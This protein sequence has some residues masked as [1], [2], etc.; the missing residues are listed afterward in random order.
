M[1]KEN[2]FWANVERGSQNPPRHPLTSWRVFLHGAHIYLGYF[3]FF[4]ANEEELIG[5]PKTFW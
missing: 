3:I 1:K 5:M 2:D 4:K